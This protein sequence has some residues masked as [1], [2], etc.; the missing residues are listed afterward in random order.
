[1]SA[2]STHERVSRIVAHREADR[3]PITDSL[4]DAT[5]QRWQ[6]EGLPA[7]AD[8]AEYLG[9]DRFVTIWADNSPRYPSR[10]IEETDD[11]LITF[12]D[13]GA[14]IKN[15]KHH[16]GVPEFLDFTS[17]RSKSKREWIRS[18]SSGSMGRIS[19]STVV[20]TP[21]SLAIWMRWKL[22]CVE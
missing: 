21:C 15:W 7:G 11:H 19:P 6:R 22:R 16:G 13:W 12:T 10:T 17:I 4:W 8:W 2:M 20:S 3:V 5:R 1:M 14:T 18:R 9:L